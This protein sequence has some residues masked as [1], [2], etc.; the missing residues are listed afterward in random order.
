[1]MAGKKEFE[2]TE[3][4]LFSPGPIEQDS[5]KAGD[6]GYVAASI[7]DVRNCRVGDTIT[8]ATRPTEKPFPGYRKVVPWYIAVSILRKVRNLKT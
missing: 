5:L 1:M 7:K 8:D 2:V 4:G 6:V 3:V